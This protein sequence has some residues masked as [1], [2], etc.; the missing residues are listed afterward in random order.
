ML[1]NL[2]LFNADIQSALYHLKA[3]GIDNV[4]NS[5]VSEL[6]GGMKR[7]LAIARALNTDFDFLVLDEPFTGLDDANLEACAKHILKVAK[8]RPII[9]VSHSLK[10]AELLNARIVN[11]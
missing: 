5:N 2:T 3:L 10:E 8:N 7:R 6:S 1:E 4:Q 11:M 9:L